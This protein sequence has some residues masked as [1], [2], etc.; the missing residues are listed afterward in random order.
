MNEFSISIIN[1]YFIILG[2]Y[3]A[4][5]PNLF[6]NIFPNNII[7]YAQSLISI[8]KLQEITIIIYYIN[9]RFADNIT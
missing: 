4:L 8:I 3:D 2:E 9:S 1:N 6:P 7:K 5:F